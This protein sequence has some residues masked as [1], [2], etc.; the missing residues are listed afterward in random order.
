M[1]G[2][3]IRTPAVAWNSLDKPYI[4]RVKDTYPRD[5]ITYACRP[6]SFLD[7]SEAHEQ[8]TLRAPRIDRAT[9][10]RKMTLERRDFLRAAT[11]GLA[12]GLAS[13][14]TAFGQKSASTGELRAGSGTLDLE[15]RLKSGVLK[16]E[17]QDL[18]DRADHSV[19]VRSTLGSTAL[20]SAMF[21]YQNDLTVFAL[22][23]DSGHSTTVVLSPSDVPKI[24][25]LVAW[26]DS[27]APQIFSLDKAKIMEADSID[28]ITDVNGKAPDL[29][30]KRKPPPF[31]WSELES[32]F[33]SDPALLAF[34]RGRK[35]THHP[36]EDDK[37]SHHPCRL[38]SLV[39]GSTL[40]LFWGGLPWSGLHSQDRFPS[41]VSG[42]AE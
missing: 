5:L 11:T 31:T 36:S 7:L 18:L 8:S 9:R 3:R 27:E 13:C 42:S 6:R 24:A 38:L 20:Y 37:L 35:S 25:R 30:G 19:I 28:D 17:A 14:E 39:P 10:V 41:A 22:F 2:F 32:V 23:H 4:P 21:S 12:F 16:L 15:G 1:R 34:M 40:S 29:V 26:N 33:G